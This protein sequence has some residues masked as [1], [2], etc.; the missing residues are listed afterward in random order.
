[1]QFNALFLIALASFATALPEPIA[2][3]G[4]TADAVAPRWGSYPSWGG[5]SGGSTGGSWWGGSTGG[6]TGGSSDASSGS[7]SGGSS[8]AAACNSYTVITTRGTG[9]AQGPSAGFRTMNSQLT[10]S[11]SGGK[12]YNTVYPAGFS[13]NSAQGT[14]DIV[15]KV[16]T[17]LRSNPN[18]CFILQGYSQGGAATTNALPKLTGSAFDAVKGVFIIGNPLHKRGLD[19]N[20][21]SNGGTT[22]KNVQ[23][24]SAGLGSGI[25]QNWVS[26]TMDVCAF[27]DG[28]CD[29]TNG[30]GI[31]GPHLSYGSD[32]NVQQMGLTFMKKQL[33]R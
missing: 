17:T 22:T 20:V 27:G 1:M 16:T 19:C 18:E 24:I 7:S 3:D 30:R 33:G 25:P 29:T 26:K 14:Q 23:G 9:E 4:N 6:S 15:N 2:V 11:T 28:V 32:R 31:N 21:D 10:S 8:S 12:L 5:S 13:Q